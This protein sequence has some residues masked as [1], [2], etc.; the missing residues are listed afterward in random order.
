MKNT[1]AVQ[2]ADRREKFLQRSSKPPRAPAVGVWRSAVSSPRS[3][4]QILLQTQL[5]DFP[6]E[7]F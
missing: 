7:F 5:D 2:K 1:D 3:L 4:G 6:D